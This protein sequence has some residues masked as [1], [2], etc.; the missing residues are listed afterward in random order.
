M[1]KYCKE[2]IHLRERVLSIGTSRSSRP[3]LRGNGRKMALSAWANGATL[4]AGLQCD[5]CSIESRR[6]G[7]ITRRVYLAKK[8]WRIARSQ[9][10]GLAFPT[11]V[12]FNEIAGGQRRFHAANFVPRLYIVRSYL[13]RSDNEGSSQLTDVQNSI[14]GLRKNSSYKIMIDSALKLCVC[15]CVCVCVCARARARAH[16]EI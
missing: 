4:L 13:F 11:F 6:I 10:G 1:K 9:R 12:L 8:L 14:F 15:V 2:W 7:S 3:T 5:I 16:T